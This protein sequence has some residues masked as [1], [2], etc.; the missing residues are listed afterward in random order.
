MPRETLTH[1]TGNKDLDAL[2]TPQPVKDIQLTDRDLKA[3]EPQTLPE[4]LRAWLGEN[5]LVMQRYTMFDYVF[6]DID[7]DHNRRSDLDGLSISL[8]LGQES[9]IHASLQLEFLRFFFPSGKYNIT[10]ELA[11]AEDL[12][13]ILAA[14]SDNPYIFFPAHD[15][16]IQGDFHSQKLFAWQ[17]TKS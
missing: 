5:R 1:L 9:A 2:L 10:M 15:H 14:K 11:D 8:T 17:I 4:G 13:R 3:I 6:P 12:T 16:D 7:Y